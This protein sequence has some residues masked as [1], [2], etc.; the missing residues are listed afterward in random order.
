MSKTSTA[1]IIKF[2]MTFVMA[3]IVF[4]LLNMGNATWFWVFVVSLVGT[5][6]NYLLGDLYVLPKFGNI[7]AS[8]GDGVLAALVAFIIDALTRF[9]DTTF[10][11]LVLFA[12]LIAVGEY[13]FHQYLKASPEVEP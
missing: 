6:L 12:L 1:L 2:I 9:F 13:F 4:E 11:S 7:V 3:A 8:I 10:A 5:A